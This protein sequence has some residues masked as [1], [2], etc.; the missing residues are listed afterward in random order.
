MTPALP[1]AAALLTAATLWPTAHAAAPV[2]YEAVH[3][4]I[5]T[6]VELRIDGARF[7]GHLGEAALQ[8]SLAGRAQGPRLDGQVQDPRSGQ[9]V[10]PMAAELRGDELL[11]VPRQPA[12]ASTRSWWAAGATSRR[13]TAPAAQAASPPSAPCDR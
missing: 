10:M 7:E 2:A 6:R 8:L 11:L 1:L 12:A 13:S 3:Q 9:A 4:G 5:V